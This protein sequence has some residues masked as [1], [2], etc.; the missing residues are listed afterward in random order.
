MALWNRGKSNFSGRSACASASAGKRPW[1][2]WPT[3][4]P[5]SYGRCSPRGCASTPIMSRSSLARLP[6]WNRSWLA[7]PK[8]SRNRI[9]VLSPPKRAFE[10]AS[11]RSD[12][13][14]ASSTNPV[15]R[16]SA[17]K[18]RNEWSPAERFVSGPAPAS[19]SATRPF[20]D[21]QSVSVPMPALNERTRDS[22]EKTNTVLTEKRKKH[23][24][25]RR[26]V[27]VS[28]LGLTRTEFWTSYADQ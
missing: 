14:Q 27:L 10:D 11:N 18:T 28:G 7:E 25:T 23:A 19:A 9:K 24:L 26:K 8:N 16:P 15:S 22:S 1:W 3:R 21:V 20:V 17:V 12:W 5:A 2:R 6:Q 13:Q 4:T